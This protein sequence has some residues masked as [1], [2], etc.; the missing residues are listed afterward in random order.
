MITAFKKYGDISMATTALKLL[1]ILAMPLLEITLL[2]IHQHLMHLM[3]LMLFMTLSMTNP[4]AS[5][6]VNVSSDMI[7]KI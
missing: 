2:I 4:L 1:I 5:I 3:L 7:H 6:P